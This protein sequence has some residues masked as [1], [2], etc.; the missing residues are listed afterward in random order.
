MPPSRGNV[1][2]VAGVL[3]EF[4][5]LRREGALSGVSLAE[6]VGGVVVAISFPLFRS[7]TCKSR[8]FSFN[9]GSK[10]QK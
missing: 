1:E 9:L 2:G 10:S 8:C 7:L 6:D 5:N 3:G 4:V